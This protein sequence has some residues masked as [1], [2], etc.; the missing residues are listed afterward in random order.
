MK[1]RI[2][3]S[4]YKLKNGE[5]SKRRVLWASFQSVRDMDYFYNQLKIENPTWLIECKWMAQ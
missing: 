3:V 4:P 1:N 2:Y 5:W